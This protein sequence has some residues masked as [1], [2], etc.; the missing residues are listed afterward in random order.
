[1]SEASVATGRAVLNP[2][3]ERRFKI[4]SL[5]MMCDEREIPYEDSDTQ[6][7]GTWVGMGAFAGDAS[8]LDAET[9]DLAGSTT[10][11]CEGLAALTVVGR[12]VLAILAPDSGPAV[13][14]A[15]PL[16]KV[17]VETEGQQGLFSKRP[18]MVTLAAEDWDLHLQAVAKLTRPMSPAMLGKTN[19]RQG[20][21]EGSLAAA[22]G[23]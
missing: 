11:A 8:P 14:V 10:I 1:M 2:T 7:L 5:E 19:S 12:R 4:G 23:S 3:R 21:Q 20:G 16:S 22:L 15:L 6:P 9:G 18:R 17:K 13:W